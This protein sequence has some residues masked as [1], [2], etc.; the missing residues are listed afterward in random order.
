MLSECTHTTEPKGTEYVLI[1]ESNS[2][3]HTHTSHGLKS[4]NEHSL[5]FSKT[6]HTLAT[7]PTALSVYPLPDLMCVWTTATSDR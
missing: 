6:E 4:L 1:T 5:E 2:S 3:E 7:E